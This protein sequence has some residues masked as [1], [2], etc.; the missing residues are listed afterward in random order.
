MEIASHFPAVRPSV[1]RITYTVPVMTG[2]SAIGVGA[3]GAGPTR[4]STIEANV[5]VYV[6]TGSR[7]L[8]R[9]SVALPTLF[10]ARAGDGVGFEP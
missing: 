9:P 1:T 4:P 7:S 10:L 8:A 5:L 2:A 3:A 6:I